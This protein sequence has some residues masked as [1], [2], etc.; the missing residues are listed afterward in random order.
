MACYINENYSNELVLGLE[1]RVLETR[2]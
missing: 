1:G 2:P